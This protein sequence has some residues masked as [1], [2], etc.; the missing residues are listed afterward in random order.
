MRHCSFLRVGIWLCFFMAA[1]AHASDGNDKN[2][3]NAYVFLQSDQLAVVKQQLRQKR[4]LP[5]TQLAYQQLLRTADKSLKIPDASV[6]QKLSISPGR[7]RHDYLSLAIYWWPD[8]KKKDGLPWIRRDGHVNPAT[9]DEHT[10]LIRL[11]GFTERLQVLALAWYFSDRQEYA[12]KAISMIRTWFIHPETRMNPN[13]D[14]AQ[15]IP[16]LTQGRGAGVLD[17]RYFST[18]VVDSLILLSKSPGWRPDDEQQVRTWMSDYLNW[19]LASRNGKQEAMAKN[20]HG[21]W[22]AVQVAGIAWYLHMPEKVKAMIALQRQKFDHQLAVDGS[23]PEEM[24]R[25]RSFHYSCFN[26]QAASLMAHLASKMGDNL[27]LY[28]TPN[29]SSLLTALDFMAPYLDEAKP[30]PRETLDRSS[31]RLLPLLLQAEQATGSRRYRQ[32]ML[33]TGYGALLAGDNVSDALQNV[34]T[35]TRRDIWLLNPATLTGAP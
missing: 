35:D 12:D 4:A 27:W 14:Y 13:L 10:D 18:R 15:A 22:Y 11:D 6:T 7:D 8:P 24:Q 3:S 30:W 25:T 29:G 5:Q 17:G 26:L 16:G 31:S 32:R 2:D 20:N 21:S 34:S 9:K 33:D 23:Q 1:L 28:R 19:L